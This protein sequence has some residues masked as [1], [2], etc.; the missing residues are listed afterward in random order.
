M[1]YWKLSLF[2]VLLLALSLGGCKSKSPTQNLSWH[3]KV[4]IKSPM[5]TVLDTCGGPRCVLEHPTLD[6]IEYGADA[7]GRVKAVLVKYKLPPE[8]SVQESRNIFT[9]ARTTM[10]KT[11]GEGK[12]YLA[13]GDPTYWPARDEKER[14]VTVTV[15]DEERT[16]IAIGAIGPGAQKIPL[17]GDAHD[18][19]KVQSYWTRI[20]KALQNGKAQKP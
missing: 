11:L 16:V 13:S 9:L 7:S 8:R 4:E 12:T 1:L 18:L 2:G 10:K 15:D 20:N 6:S 17:G 5:K 19:K 14:I 3:E